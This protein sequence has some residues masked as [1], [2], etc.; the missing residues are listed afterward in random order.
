[1]IVVAGPD[2]TG[3]SAL[4]DGLER[5]LAARGPV[6][7]FHHRV[8]VLPRSASGRTPST[9]PHAQRP[10]PV[11]LSLLKVAFLFIDQLL[12]WRMVVRRLV[13]GGGW[14]LVERGWWDIVVDPRRYR[15]R[16]VRRLAEGLGRLLPGPDLVLI[17]QAPPS[18]VHTRKAELPA[19]ELRRQ[20]GA[21]RALAPR[22]PGAVV[23]D[24][25]GAAASV[26]ADAV[27]AL[28][29]KRPRTSTDLAERRWAGLPPGGRPR[30]LVPSDSRRLARA[31]LSVH[32]PMTRAGRAGWEAA[33]ILAAA[34]LI[35]A[36]P[37]VDDQSLVELVRPFTPARGTFAVAYGREA[38]RA[39][40]LILGADGKPAGVAKIARDGT[41]RERLAREAERIHL[42]GPRLTPPLSAPRLLAVHEG[43]LLFEPVRWRPQRHPWRLP[44][45]LATAIGRFHASTVELE[46]RSGHPG[47]GDFA[48]WN[49][50]RTAGGWVL[51]DWEEASTASP[52]FA[53][54]FHYLVSAH[55][56]LGRPRRDELLRGLTGEGWVGEVLGA[57]AA[58]ASVTTDMREAFTDYLVASVARLRP[59]HPHS[60]RGRRARLR[61][62][63]A[64]ELGDR[65]RPAPM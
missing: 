1:M 25:S 33:R 14:V 6:R 20:S 24:A 60:A 65:N 51:I 41:G 42:L 10:Y 63:Q 32:Q 38:N 39:V 27:G 21:W 45:A 62:M 58:A 44:T 34:G 46:G 30:W 9:T 61:L 36:L 28:E 5:Y 12:G 57:Y 47:H 31:G 56:L 19:A 18:V 16:G 53:D 54:P 15:L 52:P 49:V 50:L 64:L 4:A 23:I 59:L 29:S 26:L 3:K 13:R 37:R 55:T 22:I 8:A 17:L 40:I 2:G 11:V 35:G 43:V 7:R 48:P